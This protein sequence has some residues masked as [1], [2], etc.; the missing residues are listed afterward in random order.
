M[1]NLTTLFVEAKSGNVEAKELLLL[2][3]EPLI[4]KGSWRMGRFDEDCYQ[5]CVIAFL[6]AIDKF[7]IRSE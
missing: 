7:E 3:F 4:R 1:K 6:L 2:R 5:E